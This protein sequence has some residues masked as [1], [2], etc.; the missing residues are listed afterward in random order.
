MKVEKIIT[1]QYG[2]NSYIIDDK[3]VVD[4]GLGIVKYVKNKVDILLTHAHFDHILGINELNYDKIYLHPKEFEMIKN[5][6]KNLSDMIGHPF[7]IKENLFDISEYFEIINTPG[8]TDGSVILFLDDHIFTGDTVFA[9]TIGRT[10]LPGGS[11]EKMENSLKI[12]KSKLKNLSQ[13]IIIHPGH[14]HETTIERI[15]EENPY[16][17]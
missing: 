12:L 1:E 5:S 8:H 6:S 15:L 13:D 3:Y 2:T 9:D 11:Q 14:M 17:F 7:E 4:P 16:L 10:D